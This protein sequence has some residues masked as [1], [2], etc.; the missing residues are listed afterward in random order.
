M[1]H[2]TPDGRALVTDDP[3]TADCI[4][5]VENHP[6]RDPYFLQ[7][8]RDPLYRKFHNKCVLYHDADRTVTTIPTIS[9][10]T[11]RRQLRSGKKSVHYIARLCENTTVDSARPDYRRERRYLFSFVGSGQTHG[12][13]RRLLAKSFADA[14]LIDTSGQRAWLMPPDERRRYE[15]EFL[16]VT[17]DS[18]FVLCPRGI[19]PCTYRLFETM[20]LGRA[21]VIIADDWAEVEGTDW[22]EFSLRVAEDDLDSIPAVLAA[23]AD[24]ALAMGRRAREV[25]EARFGPAAS[26]TTLAHAAFALVARGYTGA[27]RLVDGLEFAT[28]FHLRGLLRH[29]RRRLAARFAA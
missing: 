12:V 8:L 4:L 2:A 27:D 26:L 22:R 5:F 9:P 14:R 19:G 18:H 24:R 28:P 16:E 13:R 21:P 23:N 6:D 7:V 25:W 3:A 20:Q 17:L 29:C 15:A 11:D 1:Q 10:S